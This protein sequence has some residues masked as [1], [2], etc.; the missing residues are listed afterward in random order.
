MVSSYLCA[1]SYINTIRLVIL[2]VTFS[3]ISRLFWFVCSFYNSFSLLRRFA[4]SVARADRH[5]PLAAWRWYGYHGRCPRLVCIIQPCN[6]VCHLPANYRADAN[7]ASLPENRTATDHLPRAMR[8]RATCCRQRTTEV[9]ERAPASPACY[10]P[11][12]RN[13]L[14]NERY[15][16]A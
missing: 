1:A 5:S 10:D 2:D 9:G 14:S 4:S 6:A 15:R 3:P 12:G 16:N 8:I 7:D 13:A 11:A